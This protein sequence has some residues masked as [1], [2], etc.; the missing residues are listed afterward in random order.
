MA[1]RVPPRASA[2]HFQLLCTRVVLVHAAIE[3]AHDPI[4]RL[5]LCVQENAFLKINPSSRPT[6]PG[7]D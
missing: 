1:P 5:N 3:V 6:P 4:L 2:E 7:A